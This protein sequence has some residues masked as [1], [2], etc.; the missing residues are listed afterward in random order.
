M[1]FRSY[2]DSRYR[3]A[4]LADVKETHAKYGVQLGANVAIADGQMAFSQKMSD[5]FVIAYAD[6]SL[7]SKT[8]H[9]DSGDIMHPKENTLLPLQNDKLNRIKLKRKNIG[10]GVDLG[11]NNHIVVPE[12]GKIYLYKVGSSKIFLVSGVI[13]NEEG[14]LG[15]KMFEVIHQATKTV[16]KGFSN[17]DGDFILTRVLPG[18]YRIV[19]DNFGASEIFVIN[20]TDQALDVGSIKVLKNT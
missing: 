20:E 5:S 8:L 17:R 2:K 11:E 16:Y 3:A 14:P 4:F 10:L 9:F 18:K 19:V 1:L 15:L 7:K 12:K 6:K 13:K